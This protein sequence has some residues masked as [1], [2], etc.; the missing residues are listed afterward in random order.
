MT[1]D[2]AAGLTP[3]GRATYA[4]IVGAA[5]DLVYKQGLCNTVE[6][7]VR[8]AASVSGSQMTH[9]LK[10]RHSMTRAIIAW[11]RNEVVTFHTS[12]ELTK[13]DSFT[14]LQKWAELN[15]QKQIDVNC[16]GGCAFGSLVGEL[17]PPEDDIRGDISAVYDEWIA[18]FRTALARMRKR[19]DLRADADPLHLARVLV[20]AHQGG[21]LLSQ[22]THSINPL[23]DALNAAVYYVRSFATRPSTAAGRR[24]ARTDPAR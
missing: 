13:L 7:D 16:M 23:R 10:D 20:A 1:D 17:T 12:G 6:S 21:S 8:K 5:A 9:Y 22:T 15:I 24:T 11:R 18:L 14:A 2:A 3:R 4:R 19:G